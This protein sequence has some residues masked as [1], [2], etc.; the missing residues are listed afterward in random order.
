VA[1]S[2]DDLWWLVTRGLESGHRADLGLVR[3]EVSGQGMAADRRQTSASRLLQ[4]QC[5]ALTNI[6]NVGVV[7]S[8]K[9][10]LVSSI[11]IFDIIRLDWRNRKSARD[12]IARPF[13][14]ECP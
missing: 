1:P 2:R 13:V 14:R 4:G 10:A 12:E 3:V 7:K 6:E 8:L 9:P 5:T 11:Y